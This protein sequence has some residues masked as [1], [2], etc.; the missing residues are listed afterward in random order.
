[1]ASLSVACCAALVIK[2]PQQGIFYWRLS[3]LSRNAGNAFGLYGADKAGAS[4]RLFADTYVDRALVQI[5]DPATLTTVKGA[6]S[7]GGVDNRKHDET[8]LNNFAP[9]FGLECRVKK[10]T[11][12]VDLKASSVISIE[13]V[14]VLDERIDEPIT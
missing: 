6:M 1:M 5:Y 9:R 3:E 13:K 12:T 7:F 11:V 14:S 8:D 4:R 2:R 10:N